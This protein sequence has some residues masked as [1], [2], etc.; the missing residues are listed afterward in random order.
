MCAF[1]LYSGSQTVV[2]VQVQLVAHII[3]VYSS[4]SSAIQWRS[5]LWAPRGQNL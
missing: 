2:W 3:L 4:F 5:N 1:V